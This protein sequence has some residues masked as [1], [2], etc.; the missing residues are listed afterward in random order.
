MRCLAYIQQPI[1][2]PYKGLKPFDESDAPIFFGREKDR[3]RIVNYLR[4]L[5]LTVLYGISG[6]GKSSV[7]RAGVTYYLRQVAQQNFERYGV[8]K[9]AVVIFKDWQKNPLGK[10]IAQI[11]EE[12]EKLLNG[13]KL[14]LQSPNPNLK[15]VLQVCTESLS[16]K[17]EDGTLFIILDQF[18]EYFLYHPQ[19]EEGE[20]TFEIEFSKVVN[21][22]GL[23][24][25]FL[26]SI[27]ED[28]IAKLDRFKV[29]I[30]NIL[31]NRL[32]LKPLDEQSACDAILN[33]I[34]K[35]Y[36]HQHQEGKIGIEPELVEHILAEIA[37]E[38]WHQNGYGKSDE[39]TTTLSRP[40]TFHSS[41]L[42]V[43][44]QR[45][46]EEEMKNESCQMRLKTLEKLGG[47]K[48]VL[49]NYFKEKMEWLSKNAHPKWVNMVAKFVNYLVTPKGFKIAYPFEDLA[50]RAEI[51]ERE[52]R[53]VL[54]ELVKQRLLNPVISEDNPNLLCYE[55]SNDP[56]ASVILEWHNDYWRERNLAKLEA[57]KELSLVETQP[58]QEFFETSQ[59]GALQTMIKAGEHLKEYIEDDLLPKNYST[60]PIEINFRQIL[61][62]IQEKGQLKGYQG[63][64]CSVAFSPDG[65]FIASGSE[66]GTIALWDLPNKS[67]IICKGHHNWIWGLNFSPNRKLFATA[68]DDGTVRLWDFQGKEKVNFLDNPRSA[69]R[70][71]NFSP[72]G[73]FL[74][75]AFTDGTV[76][77]WNLE[78]KK[79]DRVLVHQASVVW[80]VRFSPDGKYLVTGSED[81]K[82][83]WWNWQGDMKE[84]WSGHQKAVWSISFSPNGKLL[85][86]SSADKTIKIWDVDK[87]KELKTLTGHKSWIFSIRFSPN[88]NLL[89][90]GSEDCTASLWDVEQGI[91][92]AKF[93]HAGPVH[94]I[95][96]SPD[97]FSLA[98]ASADRK[99]H[100]WDCEEKLI[101]RGHREISLSV[102]FSPVKIRNV[103]SEVCSSVV[104][105][106]NADG[107]VCLWDWLKK[108]QHYFNDYHQGWVKQVT[109]SPDGK[110]LATASADGTIGLWYLQN[111]KFKKLPG[112]KGPVWSIS[113]SPDEQFLASSSED[114]SIRLWDI[115]SL[116]G[117]P[118]LVDLGVIWSIC[119]SPDGQLLAGGLA[120]GTVRIWDLQ[121]QELAQ[122][123]DHKGAVLSVSFHPDPNKKLLASSSSEG[124]ICL[125][126][127]EKKQLSK[128][129]Q[130]HQVPIWCV[131][132]SPNGQYLASGS[133][134]RTAAL[135]DLEGNS[136]AVFR[137][138]KGPVRSLNFSPDGR[139]LVTASSDGT[140]R[141]WQSQLKDFDDLLVRG[142][143]LLKNSMMLQF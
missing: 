128:D 21:C 67:A 132:F 16:E 55:I 59:L 69:V 77:L 47:A 14:P 141:L 113:F 66:D 131:N 92:L 48:A 29:A 140:V 142:Q 4:S 33:P 104:A 115:E 25:N 106:G 46:W 114:G 9:F 54:E 139:Y 44:M 74:A 37:L 42:Q 98:S 2:Q 38:T 127:L 89:A 22:L 97:G 64:V 34:Y 57:E 10:L 17:G 26:I 129:F 107:T 124:K 23:G 39:E 20:V 70:S 117:E 3:D 41:Y 49:K 61:E 85:A 63:A 93:P 84:S 31:D 136:V 82:I 78:D 53:P 119:F 109:F 27:R 110:L 30:P 51:E 52:L 60:V 76:N 32:E 36:N 90:S 43:L 135:W 73:Q 18:E 65:Q 134:D 28:W 105:I 137:G 6:V 133:I 123:A 11:K 45:L 91:E 116:A 101:F 5:R 56:L 99:V 62:N 80:C 19:P 122:W 13:Q 40:R 112:H 138:H 125:W 126:D 68:S 94:C 86:S 79:R 103:F 83:C 121:S 108:Q 8:P 118:F 35:V 120:D 50:V 88:G 143:E 71:V 12:S 96:F 100:L 58:F 72:D 95:S 15:E 7:L 1:K 87:G 102:S 81:G 130:A 111:N 24:V 75:A